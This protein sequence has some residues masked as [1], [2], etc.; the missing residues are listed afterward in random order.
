[1]NPY[2]PKLQTK[3]ICYSILAEILLHEL[4]FRLISFIKSFVRLGKIER[5]FKN[6]ILSFLL[7]FLIFISLDQI[8]IKDS[9]FTIALV[10]FMYANTILGIIR[11]ILL[12]KFDPNKMIF[13]IL[14]KSFIILI[15]ILLFKLTSFAMDSDSCYL[16][17][18]KIT[19]LFFMITSTIIKL[20][21]TINKI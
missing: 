1:M 20:Y 11:N 13:G 21:K 9:H 17:L 14:I 5:S 16:Y 2:L 15:L 8:E 7:A 6:L 12:C 10:V 3:L 4:K 18:A 19:F